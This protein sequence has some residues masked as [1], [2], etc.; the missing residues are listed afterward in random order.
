MLSKKHCDKLWRIG[1]HTDKQ[2]RTGGA[3]P[4][5]MFF[6]QLIVRMLGAVLSCSV[7]VSKRKIN[8]QM[9]L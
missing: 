4:Q 8:M 6:I 2:G 9:S 5:S 1:D 7:R 3:L